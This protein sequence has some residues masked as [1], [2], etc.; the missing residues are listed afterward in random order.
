VVALLPK[1]NL[2]FVWTSC[3]LVAHSETETPKFS[4]HLCE[5]CGTRL[6]VHTHCSGIFNPCARCC[7]WCCASTAPPPPPPAPSQDVTCRSLSANCSYCLEDP[8]CRWCNTDQV[9]VSGTWS[10]P[11]VGQCEQW[12]Y[13]SCAVPPPPT[14]AVPS[15]TIAPSPTAPPPVVNIGSFWD[16]AEYLSFMTVQ[17]QVCAT[18]PMIAPNSDLEWYTAPQA[19]ATSC[20]QVVNIWNCTNNGVVRLMPV[21]NASSNAICAEVYFSVTSSINVVDWVYSGVPSGQD[22]DAGFSWNNTA[23]ALTSYADEHSPLS[24]AG[25][26]LVGAGIWYSN[27]S[28][29]ISISFYYQ[30]QL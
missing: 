22:Y 12:W 27:V 30:G 19:L 16:A 9:C 23:S 3:A 7:C 14:T 29:P 17:G 15:T 13:D 18:S 5:K 8:Q 20:C 6:Y 4:Y 10:G 1:I 2:M 28:F 26:A 11:N 24:A 25:N 21:V